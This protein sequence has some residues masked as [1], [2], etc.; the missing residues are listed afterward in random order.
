MALIVPKSIDDASMHSHNAMI[1]VVLEI[2]RAEEP[3]HKSAL[4]A[5]LCVWSCSDDDF[6]RIQY[7]FLNETTVISIRH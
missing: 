5:V 2:V 1:M 6:H 7:T 4:Y 3:V